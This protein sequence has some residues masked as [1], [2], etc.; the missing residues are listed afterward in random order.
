MRISFS[1]SGIAILDFGYTAVYHDGKA[2]RSDKY[3]AIY[4]HEFSA[5]SGLLVATPFATV[6]LSLCFFELYGVLGAGNVV[7]GLFFSFRYMQGK[8]RE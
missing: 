2:T 8:I 5:C 3:G 6:G 7:Y 1:C 4:I